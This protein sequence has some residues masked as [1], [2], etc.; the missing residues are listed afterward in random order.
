MAREGGMSYRHELLRHAVEDSL[1]PA[2]RVALHKRVLALLTPIDGTDPAVL[3]H[4]ARH[5]GDIAALLRYGVVAATSAAAQGAHREAV[6]HFRAVRPHADRL[7]AGERA[8][9][10]EQYGVEA[11]LA[12]V[13]VEG[14]SA[15]RDAQAERERLGESVRVG[16]DHRWI[17]R[18]AWWNGRGGEAR[19]AAARAVE[20]LEAVGPSRELAMA[21][22]NRS[23]LHMLADEFAEAIEWGERAR[24]LADQLG[25]LDTSVHASINV[26]AARNLLGDASAPAALWQIHTTAAAGGAVE[27][28]ARAL[29]VLSSSSL[30]TWNLAGAD[31]MVEH[32][33]NYAADSNLEGYVQYLLGVRASIRFHLCDW[34]AALADADDALSRPNRIGVAVVSALVVRGRIQTARDD[35]GALSTLDRAAEIAADT[36]ELQRIGPVAAARAEHF[37]LC[38]DPG[39]AAEEARRGLR[40]AVAKGQPWLAGELACW[41]WRAT[42]EIEGPVIEPTPHHLLMGGDWESAARAWADRASAYSRLEALSLGD[43]AAVTEALRVLSGLGAVRTARQLR[44]EVSRRGVTSVPRGPR[45]TT[46]NNA[47][48]LTSRQLQV[49]RMLADGLSNAD[50]AARLTL[51]HKTVEH[52]VS[53]V[54]NKL[55]VT[56]RGQAIAAAH[57]LHLVS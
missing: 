48:G 12:G 56:T 4:H 15:L 9:L 47:A 37:L 54:L 32:A 42:G 55:N 27:H 16:E 29:A 24:D 44:V 38:G 26:G 35:P 3:V 14:L 40:L 6:A 2:R 30:L 28:A 20:V 31:S 41:I 43:R 36:G 46:A 45:S 11:Y 7:P 18:L 49:L 34:N 33:L 22:S 53:A 52:H 10:L 17:S 51:S 21:Y 25:D 5:G 50:I 8:R 13:A 39:R 57:R 23:Q 19:K 1:S